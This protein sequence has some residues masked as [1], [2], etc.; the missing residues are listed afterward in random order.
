MSRGPWTDATYARRRGDLVVWSEG[1]RARNQAHQEAA[2]ERANST[3]QLRREDALQRA[4]RTLVREVIASRD[5]DSLNALKAFQVNLE[6]F[7]G[8]A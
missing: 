1:R 5:L 3:P 6:A 7:L 8:R 2:E 4:W